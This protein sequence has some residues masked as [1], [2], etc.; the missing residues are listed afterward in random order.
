[1]MINLKDGVTVGGVKPEAVLA[2]MVVAG[3]YQNMGHKHTITSVTDGKHKT[4]S[5]HYSGFAFD[6][7]TWA[8]DSGT[9]LPDADKEKLAQ[10]IRKALG[11]EFDVVVEKTHIHVEF[12]PK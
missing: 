6:N 12:D 7:R 9:Q 10:A 11:S 5:L 1:M 2:M 3:V 4:G 8:D